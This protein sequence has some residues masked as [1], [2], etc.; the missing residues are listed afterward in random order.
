MRDHV[1]AHICN[2]AAPQAPAR[3]PQPPSRSVSPLDT[4]N[5][6]RR[7]K[8]PKLGDKKVYRPIRRNTLS[9]IDET[10]PAVTIR[11]RSKSL[12]HS[13]DFS[14]T[15]V[16]LRS[17]SNISADTSRS[18]PVCNDSHEL[19]NQND[20]H[21]PQYALPERCDSSSDGSPSSVDR[22]PPMPPIEPSPYFPQR[23]CYIPYYPHLDHILNRYRWKYNKK[24]SKHSNVYLAFMY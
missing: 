5:S 10:P 19:A 14:S 12:Q 23:E 9:R 16:I 21:S 17:H 11:P 4:Y 3:N 20:S 2:P 7:I 18:V 6:H 13:C 8:R 24:M 15:R 1:A 22:V